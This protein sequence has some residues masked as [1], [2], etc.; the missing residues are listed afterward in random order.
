MFLGLTISRLVLPHSHKEPSE[1][2]V[3]LLS[4]AHGHASHWALQPITLTLSQ[5]TI[6]DSSKLKRVCRRRFKIWWKWEQVLLQGRKHWGKR[7]NCSLRAISPFPTVFSK[8]LY[9]RHVK[10][11]ACFGVK[12]ARNQS[13]AS[14]TRLT[15]FCGQR[16]LTLTLYHRIKF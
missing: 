5:M 11:R 16:S 2:A 1:S 14:R 9:C 6:L 12:A 15:L 3:R 13:L 7:R 10:T 8:D 4:R